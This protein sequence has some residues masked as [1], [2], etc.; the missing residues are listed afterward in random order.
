MQLLNIITMSN[1]QKYGI[2]A[3]LTLCY[4]GAY[5]HALPYIIP[6]H[7]QHHLFLYTEEYFK[8]IVHWEGIWSYLTNFI[9]QFFHYP[10]FGGAILSMMIASTYLLTR[11]IIQ[12]LFGKED[13]L[14]LSVIPSMTLF[15]H[16]MKISH[17]LVP[18]IITV[19]ALSVANLILWTFRR[20]QPFFPI[21]NNLHIS[22][23]TL[24]MSF[25]VAPLFVYAGYGSY[26][27]IKTYD[28]EEGILQK[29]HMYSKEKNWDKTLKYTHLYLSGGK[30]NHLI[31]YFHHLALYHKGELLYRLFE[32]PQFLGVNSL[33]L[34]WSGTPH[35]TEYGH[36]IYEN[37]GHI[38]EAL[39]WESEAMVV[40]G[41]N[42]PHLLKLIQY[43]ILIQRP[44]IAQL[45]IDKLKQSLFYRPKAL[46]L[47]TTLESGKIAG[48]KNAFEGV[49]D[50]PARFTN[51]LNIGSE[52]EY[53]CN[54]DP[55]NKMAFEYYM[56]YLLLS[57]NLPD[58]AHYLS[59]SRHFQHAP[60]PSALEEA[61][62]L[63]KQEVNEEEWAE[64]GWTIS[65]ETETRFARY[66]QLK[67]NK[68]LKELQREFEESYWF[69]Q[70][71]IT[72]YKKK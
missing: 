57:N 42:A 16:T 67:R 23:K 63:Y 62:L 46:Q 14:S 54:H 41:E 44:Q 45:F 69:Y 17:S 55:K 39:H 65:P 60:I 52:L 40:W 47:E 11:A 21:F 24:R 71:Y 35:E 58:L 33:Y 4:W 70:D 1:K 29:A 30:P 27:F 19:S 9:I 56:C 68:Q 37:L 66:N 51:F 26:H 32:H 18:V 2:W 5:T 7:E 43:N 10:L 34:P 6:Y 22:S 64:T 36:I 72:P 61:L 20:Y 25:A 12:R 3:L 53:L 31:S 48:M 50:V 8:Q 38:N 15:F 59:R 49:T 28:R 13:L